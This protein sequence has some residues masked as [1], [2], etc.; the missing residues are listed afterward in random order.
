MSHLTQIA[1]VPDSDL[2]KPGMAF[3]AG[4]GPAGLTCKDCK[5]RGYSRQSSRG[6]WSET[7]KDYVYRSYRV[8]SC[9]QYLKMTGHHGTPVEGDYPSCKYFQPV[10]EKEAAARAAGQLEN[11]QGE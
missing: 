2:A 6:R 9:K 10:P 8:Q 11:C 7:K 4:T 5:L 1:D 3:F